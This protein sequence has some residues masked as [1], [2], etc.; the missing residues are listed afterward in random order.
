MPVTDDELSLLPKRL[1]LPRGRSALPESEVVASQ[2]GRIMHAVTDE[3]AE[4]GYAK[5]TVAGITRR[6]RVSRTTF[7]QSFDDKEHAFSAA[8]T[9]ISD[10]VVSVIRDR[11]ARTDDSAWRERIDLGVRALVESFESRPAYARSYMVE[12]RGAGE[13][14]LAQRDRVVERHARSLARVAQLAGEAGAPVRQPTELEVIAAIGG[15]EELIARAARRV[16][17][18]GRHSF[19]SII[20]A[21]VTIH[22]SVLQPD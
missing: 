17:P 14:L 8:Y 11:A 18:G 13:R 4:V 7:Y 22:T 9:A 5:A 2:R 16:G 3:V 19:R 20:P 1:G 15:T 12:V 10:Q 21:I 6:A